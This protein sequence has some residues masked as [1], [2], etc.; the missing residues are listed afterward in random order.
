MTGPAVPTWAGVALSLVLVGLAAAVALRQRLGLGGDL[1]IATVRAAAQLAA[2][3]A[4]LLLV[5]NHA[6][7]PG[8]LGWVAL[9]VLVAGQVAGR[10]GAGLPHARLLCTVAVAV[11]PTATLGLL[12]ALRVVGAEPRIV[13][14]VGGM[15]VSGA[16]QA[17]AVTVVRLAEQARAHRA[18]IEARLCLGLPATEAF[19]PHERTALRTA[20]MPPVDS[21]K[22]VGLISLPGAMTGLILAGVAPLTAI[23]YQI[24]VMYMLLAAAAVSALTAVWLA[25]RVLFDAAHR[26]RPLAPPRPRPTGWSRLAP[27]ARSVGRSAPVAPTARG[28]GA[29]GGVAAPRR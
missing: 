17:T 23:R 8:A 29:P 3:G 13:I 12:I 1:V 6:G 19:R 14:P 11:G 5:F 27:F 2:V 4:V 28:T 22:V 9:M 15:V 20:M 26:L 16:M 7:I 18:A 24:V 10:R 21:T 25:R